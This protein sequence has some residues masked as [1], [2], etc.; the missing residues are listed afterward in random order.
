MRPRSAVACAAGDSSPGRPRRMPAGLP[1]SSAAAASKA[2]AAAAASASA[3]SASSC[4]TSPGVMLTR[5]RRSTAGGPSSPSGQYRR[6]LPP[7]PLG[8][9]AACCALSPLWCSR[10]SAG[11]SGTMASVPPGPS[12]SCPAGRYT[13]IWD[14][15]APCQPASSS[16]PPMRWLT[17]GEMEPSPSPSKARCC[18]TRVAE[19]PAVSRCMGLPSSSSQDSS[20]FHFGLDSRSR[21]FPAYTAPR[22]GAVWTGTGYDGKCGGQAGDASW[23]ATTARSLDSVCM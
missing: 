16:A 6:F 19:L 17:P 1:H 18:G 2:A 10:C 20:T 5:R 14:G 4:I 15:P 23:H 22:I 7:N 11:A 13:P 3:A 12:S 9:C 8:R 21:S